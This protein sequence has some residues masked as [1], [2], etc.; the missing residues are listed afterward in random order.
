MDLLC[1]HHRNTPTGRRP[2]SH[3]RDDQCRQDSLVLAGNRRGGLKQKEKDTPDAEKKRGG[4]AS[5]G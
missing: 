5:A 1:H 4:R 2:F 3:G